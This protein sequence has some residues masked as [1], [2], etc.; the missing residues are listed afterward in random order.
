[1]PSPEQLGVSCA[2]IADKESAEWTAARQRLD[3]LGAVGFQMDKTGQGGFRFTCL[4]PTVQPGRIHRIDAVAA[5]EADA[6]RLAIDKA[7]EW[8]L[9]R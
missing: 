7:E 9:R 8:A 3:R 5:T 6:V 1:M 4:L 2:K